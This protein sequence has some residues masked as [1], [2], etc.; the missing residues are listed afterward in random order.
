MHK[1]LVLVALLLATALPLGAEHLDFSFDFPTPS[2]SA[3]GS[4]QE[5]AMGEL[6]C[7]VEPGRPALPFRP[8]RLLVPFDKELVRSEILVEHWERLDGKIRLATVAPI[9]PISLQRPE[10]RRFLKLYPRAPKPEASPFTRG[11]SHVDRGVQRLRGHRFV[12]LN[13]RPV[14]AD[15]ATETVEWAPRMTVRLHLADAPAKLEPELAGLKD[16]EATRI[17]VA[18]LVENPDVLASYA[19]RAPR[20]DE[21][22]RVDYLVV[23]TAFLAAAP[24]PDNLQTFCAFLE[25]QG[26][27]TKIVLDEELAAGETGE[28]RAAKIRAGIA[29]HHREHGTAWVLL[30]GDAHADTIP[31]RRLHADFVWEGRTFSEELAA[32]IYYACLDGDF[33][34]DGDG[35]YGEPG[36]GPDGGEVDLYAE[37]A[38]GRAPRGHP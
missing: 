33:D 11:P 28:D 19:D 7:A 24:G 38:V 29:R 14:R 2:L 16:D 12:D 15:S 26:L 23:T 3:R 31:A 13:L 35:R 17:R 34:G 30:A 8:V 32:D 21:A 9:G 37:L 25:E 4:V 1:S 10:R 27:K 5:L 20:L 36:D 22:E 6:P 18:R